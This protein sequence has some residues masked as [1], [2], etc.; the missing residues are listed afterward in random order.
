MVEN[1]SQFSAV[2]PAVHT[3]DLAVEEENSIPQTSL[4]RHV[5]IRCMV[6]LVYTVELYIVC[7]WLGGEGREGKKRETFLFLFFRTA[8]PCLVK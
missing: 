3:G 2:K 4:S 6:L 5:M 7:S 1:I 8:V